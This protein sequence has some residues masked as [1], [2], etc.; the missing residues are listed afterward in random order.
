MVSKIDIANRAL[1]NVGRAAITALSEVTLL[2]DTYDIQRRALL[3]SH[4]WNFASKR[5]S[6]NKQTTEPIFTWTNQYTL[7]SD[8]I[9]LVMTEEEEENAP[10]GDPLFNGFL[11]ISFSSSFAKA[12]DYRIEDSTEGKILLSNDDVKRI[13]YIFDQEDSQRF[14]ATFVTLL[15]KAIGATMAYKLTGSRTLAND[16]K[17]D[18]Q[19]LFRS[20]TT[21][22]GQQSKLRRIETSVFTASRT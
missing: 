13:I 7:P 19:E 9:R 15:A 8:F 4:P 17:Q 16:E 10:L 2:E 6:L 11:T 1:N 3:E 12:D 20:A 18:F 14:S 5:A 21:V 22:D